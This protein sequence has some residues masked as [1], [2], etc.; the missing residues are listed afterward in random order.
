M[1]SGHEKWCSNVFKILEKLNL[2]HLFYER[3]MVD[4]KEIQDQLMNKQNDMWKQA[5]P[6]KPIL[7]TYC[8]F[9]ETM[10][11]ETYIKY[12]LSSSE[13]SAMAQ[14]RFNLEFYH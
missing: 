5:V 14:F 7:R 3:K 11:I 4:I 8:L 10:D 6:K 1:Q 2:E 12:N 13:R 9:K